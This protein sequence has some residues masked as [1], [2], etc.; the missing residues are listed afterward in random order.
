MGGKGRGV[1]GCFGRGVGVIL[2]VVFFGEVE[3]FI[4]R[5]MCVGGGEGRRLMFCIFVGIIM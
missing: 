1:M 5:F 2:E 3:E 4:W